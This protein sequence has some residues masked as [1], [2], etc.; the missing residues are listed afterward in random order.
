[1]F[2]RW[3]TP[4]AEARRYDARFFMTELPAGQRGRHDDHET[5][6]SVWATPARMLDAFMR[7]D[8]FL[9]PPTIR[10]FELLLGVRSS[11]EAIA[12]CAAQSLA[13]ICPELVST[14]PPT[15][16]LPGDRAHSVREPAVAGPTRFV[17][18]DGKFV[19]EG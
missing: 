9:A 4:R 10:A 16:A 15:L 18:R 1:P 11:A 13:P 2:A 8:V 12:L 5:T 19:S 7:G 17:L 3:V 14:D 6:S